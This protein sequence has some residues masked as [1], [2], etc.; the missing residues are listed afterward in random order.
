M[1]EGAVDAAALIL[2][3]VVAVAGGALSLFLGVVQLEVVDGSSL[4][5]VVGLIERG[6]DAQMGAN[7]R[8]KLYE[9]AD[10]A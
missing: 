9:V 4:F 8:E 1:A 5:I 2:R 6:A 3:R 7:I 10:G